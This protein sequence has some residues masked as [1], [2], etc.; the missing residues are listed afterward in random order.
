MLIVAVESELLLLAAAV[1]VCEDLPAQV[2]AAL[3]HL[4]LLETRRRY[5][6]Q[7]DRRL[8]IVVVAVIS[9][10]VVVATEV[11]LHDRELQERVRE[12]DAITAFLVVVIILVIML[13]L[14]FFLIGEPPL[15]VGLCVILLLLQ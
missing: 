9:S 3:R 6:V 5:H 14:H 15:V 7:Q 12:F 1:H 13:L 10:V 8:A 2:V 4:P 11:S